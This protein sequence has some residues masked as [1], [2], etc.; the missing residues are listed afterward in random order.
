MCSEQ[1]A[2]SHS[3]RGY[4]LGFSKPGISQ[5]IAMHASLAARNAAFL[6]FTS[7]V[8][9][10]FPFHNPLPTSTVDIFLTYV[11]LSIL[12]DMTSM[13]ERVLNINPFSPVSE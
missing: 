10:D 8:H 4:F 5:I 3:V 13:S 9:S 6:I 7:L 1:R 2:V 11:L 12:L